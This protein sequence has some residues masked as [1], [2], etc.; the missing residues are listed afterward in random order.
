MRILVQILAASAL[1]Q[2]IGLAL[3]LL[4][5]VLVDQVI[6]Y[7]LA[8]VMS[9]LGAGTVILVAALMVI[10]YLRG[11]LLIYLQGRLDS[12]MT[13][14]LFEHLL[15]LP[16]RFFQLR[17]TGDLRMRLGSTTMI[18]ETLTNRTVSAVLDGTFVLVYLRVTRIVIAHRLS[19]I[20]NADLILVLD[21]GAVVE[22]GSHDGL[23]AMH[24]RYAELIHSQLQPETGAVT[25]PAS[26]A[27]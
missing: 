12:E 16:F 25:S 13:I 21:Q 15:A 19:T 1:L 18:R 14:G 4:T 11:V 17:N 2:A 22:R 10:G 23:L 9:L 3:P 26:D 24:G 20:R 7:H 5:K 6:P 27:S 8:G